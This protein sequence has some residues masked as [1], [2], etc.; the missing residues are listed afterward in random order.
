MNVAMSDVEQGKGGINE[1]SRKYLNSN[2]KVRV[3]FLIDATNNC[4]LNC[5]YCYYGKKGKKLM[6]VN[7]V[8]MACKN[9]AS[10]FSGGLE[11]IGFHY[12]GGEPLLAWDRI[13][14][15]NEK[16]RGYFEEIGI[17]FKWSLTS[18]LVALD[19][20][21]AEH[22][23]SENARIH[24][25]IDGPADIHDNNRPFKNGHGSF[26][27]V[28]K[29]IPLAV[30]I[31]PDDTARVTVRA[32]DARRM[33]EIA[34]SIFKYGFQTVGL[35]PARGD[36]WSIDQV[37][38]WKKGIREAFQL[39]E[40]IYGEKRRIS[41]IVKPGRVRTENENKFLYCGAGKGLWGISGDGNLYFCHHMTN[42]KNMAIINAAIA[43]P[44][45]IRNAIESSSLPPRTAA[46]N[47]NCQKCLAID[48]CHGNCWSDNVIFSGSSMSPA[49]FNCRLK[50]ATVEA[51]SSV[52]SFSSVKYRQQK[53]CWFSCD[54]DEHDGGGDCPFSCHSGDEDSSD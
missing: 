53:M 48:Y 33:P 29:A 43:T 40:S 3:D 49:L 2:K 44:E 20:K 15:L 21:K 24:C 31:T 50:I 6:D 47:V 17:A 26:L 45:E 23:I 7:K 13:L 34:S 27:H 1:Y 36:E 39:T 51:L 19:E 22:M 10:V 5:A 9:M 8:L 28:M 54:D 11:K 42:D 52:K 35:F 41:T 25:S 12:M 38:D 32:K 30:N 16:A 37:I 18:N 14:H 4:Q 46:I